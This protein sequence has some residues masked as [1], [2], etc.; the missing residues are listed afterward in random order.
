M[1]LSVGEH[2]KYVSNMYAVIKSLVNIYK[3]YTKA[4]NAIIPEIEAAKTKKEMD[5]AMY[6]CS[7]IDNTYIEH[8]VLYYYICELKDV[9]SYIISIES[10]YECK[11][12]TPLLIKDYRLAKKYF[13]SLYFMNK[14]KYI[15]Y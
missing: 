3:K 1:S 13:H 11:M 2:R 4:I 9:D 15:K 7:E 12:I 14:D 6:K 10:D 5:F 8:I